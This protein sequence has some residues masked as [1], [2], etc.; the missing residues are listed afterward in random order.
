MN[1]NFLSDFSWQRR[2]QGFTLVEALVALGVFAFA[3]L[4]FLMAFDTALEAAREVRREA[5]IRQILEDRMAWLEHAPLEPGESRLEGPIPGMLIREE[6]SQERLVDER[7]NIYDGFWRVRVLV[8]WERAGEKETMEAG[9]LR[10][11]E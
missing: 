6:I 5:M 9:F 3:V 8:E 7:Q 10:Y 11:G 1:K 4:G 2:K